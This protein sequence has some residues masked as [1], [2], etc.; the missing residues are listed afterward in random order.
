MTLRQIYRIFSAVLGWS[1]LGLQLYL[2]IAIAV[3]NELPPITGVMKFFDYFTILSNILVATV[4]TAL[5]ARS[6]QKWSRFFTHPKV[7][8]GVAVY[9]FI[10][11]L[12][13]FL[14]LRHTW[15]PKGLALVA[16]VLL[17]YGMPVLYGIE[18]LL[19]TPRGRLRWQDAFRWLV[20]PLGF[21]LWALFWGE[22]FGFYPYPF[23]DVTALGYPQVLLNSFFMA[24]GF[25]GMGLV[26]VVSDRWLKKILP[27]DLPDR[28]AESQVTR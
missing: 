20:F 28:I 24:V 19:F 1:A 27:A 9:I 15:N 17:H 5:C 16:D 2:L 23:I 22:V 13:Y 25:L 21:V 7:K 11:G 8:T 12:V 14:I 6:P 26:L 3:K 18:W 10:T 4:F